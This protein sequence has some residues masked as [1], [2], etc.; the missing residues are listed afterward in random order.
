MPK[1][2]REL[3]TMSIQ[4][5]ETEISTLD[6]EVRAMSDIAEIEQA[7]TRKKDLLARKKHLEDFYKRKSLESEIS[8]GGV[9]PQIFEKNKRSET[10]ESPDV[11]K[12]AWL[13]QIRDLPLE[14]VEQRAMTT[15]TASAGAVIPTELA[16]KIIDKVTQYAP[17]LDKIDLF[18]VAGNL[19]IPTEGT[20]IEASIHT[21]G[22]VITEDADTM[23]EVALTG[24]EVTKLVTISKAVEKMSISVF[25]SWLIKKIAKAIAD[26]ISKLIIYGT[27]SSEP[28][29]ID[30]IT[31]ST[32]NSVTVTSSGSLTSA[33]VRS[34]VALLNGGYDAE[35]VWLMSKTTFYSDFHPLMDNDSDNVVTCE[36]GVYRVLGYDIV[37]DERVT[38][39]DAYLGDFENGYAGN[40]AEDI[41]ITSDFMTRYNS[42]D[43]LGC[44]IFDGKVSA[45]EAFVKITK[46]TS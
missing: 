12:R 34:A 45:T 41:T 43:F 6:T 9:I 5:V 3:E 7:T 11:Y 46:A 40:L 4:D 17:L 10:F 35:A 26:K 15:A 18:H 21:Q 16:N 24:Y 36:N 27:G 44:A 25:E 20:T 37:L 29:G 2:L 31:W 28:Q 13:K 30:K 22:A 8:D 42:Y 38:L 1:I 39:H 14:D 19:T 33:N 32:T 23:N